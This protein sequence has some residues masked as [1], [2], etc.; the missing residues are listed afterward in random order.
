MIFLCPYLEEQHKGHP[1]VVG[2]NALLLFVVIAEAR[3]RDAFALG[4]GQG[5]RVGNP[6]VR[7]QDM[8]GY[9][10][11]VYTR[12]RITCEKSFNINNILVEVSGQ[13]RYS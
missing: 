2:M 12:N 1:L 6:A 11:V 9:R 5:E 10:A 4:V 7:V 13:S 3:V 8:S